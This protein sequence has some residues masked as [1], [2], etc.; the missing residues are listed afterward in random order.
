MY[1]AG[2][3]IVRLSKQELLS[4]RPSSEGQTQRAGS[5]PAGCEAHDP[6]ADAADTFP[7]APDDSP[8]A[9]PAGLHGLDEHPAPAS[10]SIPTEQLT[11][12]ESTYRL[13]LL[14]ACPGR[15]PPGVPSG[16]TMHQA[17]FCLPAF[18][19]KKSCLNMRQFV[20]PGLRSVTFEGGVQDVVWWCTCCEELSL[21]QAMFSGLHSVLA[22]HEFVEGQAPQCSHLRIVLSIGAGLKASQPWTSASSALKE[23]SRFIWKRALRRGSYCA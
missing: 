15:M 21:Q 10:T 4:S 19:Q 11:I 22:G 2:S 17:T 18:D 5:G 6:V 14:K 7:A 3:G 1:R 9:S 13:L 8:P 12:E 16:K 23:I 20:F